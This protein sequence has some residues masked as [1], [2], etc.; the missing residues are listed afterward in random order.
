MDQKVEEN[1]IRKFIEHYRNLDF[2]VIPVPSRAKEPIIKWKEYQER[3]ATDDEVARWFP[4]GYKGNIA[5][6]LGKTSGNLC[7]IDCDSAE[8][9]E[10]LSKALPDTMIVKSYR[11]GHIYI[12]TDYEIC[13][14]TLNLGKYGK[15][16]V[17]GQGQIG[18][19]PP[20]LH[21]KGITYE[22]ISQKSVKHWSGDF[23]YELI[24]LLEKL[25]GIKV[26]RESINTKKLLQGVTE[27]ERDVSAIQLA[28]W[29][30]KQGL[31]KDEVLDK[32]LEWNKLNKPPLPD[33]II[34]VKVESAFRPEMP[35]NYTFIESKKKEIFSVGRDLEDLVFEQAGEEYIVFNKKTQE[36][37]RQKTMEAGETFVPLEQIPWK[38][39]TDVRPYED[40]WS[41]VK[42]F[43]YEHIDIPSGYDILTAWVLAT[44]ISEKWDAV[45]YL[46]FYG[47]AGSGKTWAL[48]VLASISFRPFMS[49]STTLPVIF[50]ACDTWHPTL[51]LDETEVYLRKERSE[52]M[53]LL[54]AGYRKGFPATR[55][56]ETDD[57]LKVK[58]FDCF[59]FKAL[60][61]T[62]AFV[63]TLR[64][65]CIIF[66][67]S[68][69]T[70]EIKTKIDQNR[71]E[72]L[73]KKLLMYRFRMFA[74]KQK[75]E[76]PNINLT[77]RLRELFLP[78]IM[79]AT[80]EAK[81][82]IMN[83]AKKI[84]EI[85]KEE[86]QASDEATVFRAIVTAH[87]ESP[88]ATKISI[89]RITQIVNEGLSYDEVFSNFNVGRIASRLG[90]KRAIHD[91][92]RCI[93]WN[94][95]LVERLKKRWS[96]EE[97]QQQF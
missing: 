87:E 15:L 73:R 29:Y 36:I 21:P 85:T 97:G 95:N 9:L 74:E 51:F 68:K 11:G 84:E 48:E 72:E 4:D 94:E 43:L 1:T 40:I 61:G 10:I 28:T 8:L 27:G 83:E 49:A 26:K 80:A 34:E 91:K 3:K 2:N 7:D 76:E 32:L 13:K 59:G 79:V 20:S 16:E 37:T 96:V 45:P 44:W 78:L 50:R 46:F 12:R 25:L 38:P 69:A 41:E 63:D 30:R 86:E 90:F 77:G 17:L 70:R 65:R 62:R 33:N 81:G 71:A 47:P 57:G 67:M 60:A 89:E 18:I 75:I 92:R 5:V 35:Y 23:R 53:H 39:V 93:V 14:F 82:S 24:D 52:I 64:S 58:I 54:N 55:I 56:E 6:L 31:N 88:G 66:T 22:F 19:L 42:Q